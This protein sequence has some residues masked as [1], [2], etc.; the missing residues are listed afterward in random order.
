MNNKILTVLAIFGLS[1]Q[2]FAGG[3]IAPIETSEVIEV[4]HTEE[5]SHDAHGSDFYIIV[6]GLSILGDTVAHGHDTLDGDPGYGFGIDLGYRIGNGFA[7]EYDFSHATNTVT[8]TD[9]HGLHPHEGDATYTTHA[10][11]L[12]YTMHVTDT[13]GVFVKGGYESETEEIEE[14][15]IDKDSDG[16]AYAVGIEYAMNDHYTLM[17]EYEG[18]DIEGPRGDAVFVGVMYNF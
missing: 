10:I 2:L 11:H 13:F 15:H 7:V 17:A 5:V 18:S 12:V 4:A 14:F 16:F 1:T 6:K 8:E 9:D 3:A